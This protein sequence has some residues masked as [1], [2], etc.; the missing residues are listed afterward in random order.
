[1]S[2]QNHIKNLEEI[3]TISIR[4]AFIINYTAKKNILIIKLYKI[5]FLSEGWVCPPPLS[6]SEQFKRRQE[7]GDE[8]MIS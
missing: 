5:N 3:L 2:R 1:M 8:M 6:G 7:A 4:I